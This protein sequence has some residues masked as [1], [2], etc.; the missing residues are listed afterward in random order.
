M[1][2]TKHIRTKAVRPISGR[3]FFLRA[4]KELGVPSERRMQT[5]KRMPLET[6][7]LWRM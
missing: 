2:K 6:R 3:K 5:W 1:G 7:N 4:K